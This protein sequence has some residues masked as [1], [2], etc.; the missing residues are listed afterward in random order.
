M[1]FRPFKMKDVGSCPIIQTEPLE[2]EVP[3]KVIKSK[4]KCKIK[5]CELLYELF[6]NLV[7]TGNAT[8]RDYWIWTELFVLIHNGKDYCWRKNG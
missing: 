1:K 3:T 8:N 2:I 7:K 4:I 5:E 6:N